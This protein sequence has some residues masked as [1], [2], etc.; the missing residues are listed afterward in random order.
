MQL[1]AF[2]RPAD[3]GFSYYIYKHGSRTHVNGA[4]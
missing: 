3:E 4:L 1:A 2:D